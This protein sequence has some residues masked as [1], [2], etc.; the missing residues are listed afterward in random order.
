MASEEMP[1]LRKILPER[2]TGANPTG[3]VA[4]RKAIRKTAARGAKWFLP[5]LALLFVSCLGMILEKPLVTLHRVTVSPRS[6]TELGLLLDLEVK[7]PNRF[8]ITLSS[9]EYTVFL[10]GEPI[11]AGRLEKELVVPA[12]AT[13]RL[14]APVN[15]NFKDMGAIFKAL[16]AGGDKPPYAFEGK[17]TI[18]TSFGRRDFTFSRAEDSRPKEP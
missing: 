4:M 6:F 15:A 3:T 17:A 7:N 9:F 18:T 5:V 12:A 1:F 8:D 16:L 10:N 14:Q 11:G 2:R 13:T